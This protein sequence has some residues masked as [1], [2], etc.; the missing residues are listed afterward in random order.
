[1]PSHNSISVIRVLT[2]NTV[3]VLD[4]HVPYLKSGYHFNLLWSIVK[5]VTI[6]TQNQ[7]NKFPCLHIW[8]KTQLLFLLPEMFPLSMSHKNTP[9]QP[10]QLPQ[11]P[12]DQSPS[13]FPTSCM[14]SFLTCCFH[15][16]IFF[17]WGLVF[18]YSLSTSRYCLH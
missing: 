15:L 17:L 1:L 13:H 5:M 18:F 6:E 10:T 14:L 8:Y 3:K 16:E 4:D 2:Q 11:A 12:P 9:L 7:T